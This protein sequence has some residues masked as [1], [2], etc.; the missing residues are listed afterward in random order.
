MTGVFANEDTS[1]RD[2]FTQHGLR[3][4]R[5]R[6]ALYQAL[7]DNHSHPTAEELYKQVQ[8]CA[9]SMGRGTVYNTLETLCKAGLARQMPTASGTCRY[10]ADTAGHVHVQMI[11]TSEIRDVPVELAEQLVKGLP[12]AVVADIER[13]LGVHI[14]GAC[15]QL[16]SHAK[17]RRTGSACS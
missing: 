11:E 8:T 9:G 13:A 16:I 3:C 10:D 15:I 5:Q 6:V 7:R 14:D 17:G 2:V 12:K 4:T 1:V